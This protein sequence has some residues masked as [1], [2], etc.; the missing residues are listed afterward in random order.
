MK[1]IIFGH[2]HDLSASHFP[3]QIKFDVADGLV[4][5]QLSQVTGHMAL[6]SALS[7]QKAFTTGTLNCL[8]SDSQVYFATLSGTENS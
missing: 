8:S 4:G 2:S 7:S 1:H 5:T 6:I 3:H